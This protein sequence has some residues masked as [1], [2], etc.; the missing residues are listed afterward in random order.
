MYG[1]HT[2]LSI[3]TAFFHVSDAYWSKRDPTSLNIPESIKSCASCA[4][5]IVTTSGISW[6]DAIVSLNFVANAPLVSVTDQ[7]DLISIPSVSLAHFVATLFSIVSPFLNLSSGSTPHTVVMVT[8]VSYLSL[9]T[10][11]EVAVSLFAVTCFS[12]FLL[13][14]H[15]A[16]MA[17]T[18][19]IQSV[20]N[21]P[22]FEKVFILH[23]PYNP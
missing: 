13:P 7:S 3:S 21:N 16:T 22:F 18:I 1:S 23:P 4:S 15:P 19:I 6:P 2:W 5:P 20:N 11:S 8:G 9:Y 17:T 10:F 14:E 12:S